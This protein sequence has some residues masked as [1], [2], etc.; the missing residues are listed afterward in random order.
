MGSAL[1]GWVFFHF[2]HFFRWE[3]Y[4]SRFTSLFLGTAPSTRTFSETRIDHA[5]Y[6]YWVQP[7]M[8]VVDLFDDFW[9][10][11]GLCKQK[12]W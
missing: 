1:L 4:L 3:R 5:G 12:I 6:P 10:M 9:A 2:S 8:F 11:A 7:F